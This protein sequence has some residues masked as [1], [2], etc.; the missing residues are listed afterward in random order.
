[1]ALIALVTY[2]TNENQKAKFLQKTLRSL[3]ETVDG[4]KHRVYIVNNASTGHLAKNIVDGYMLDFN[5]MHLSEN[6]G[7]ARGINQAW[8]HRRPGEHCIKMDDDVV[9][10]NAGW[11]DEME[12][13]IK[14]D[15]NIGIVGLKRKDCWE[16]PDETEPHKKSELKMINPRGEKWCIVEKMQHI[17]GTCQMYNSALLDKIGYLYQPGLYGY[18]DVLASHRSQIAGFY[19]CMIPHIEIDHI[20]PGDTPYQKWKESVSGEGGTGPEVRQI[21]R[22]YYSGAKSIYHELY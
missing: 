7:T 21:I 6:I 18:D 9:I 10:H 8:R 12:Y 3:R 20:D 22:D 13:A 15:P 5:V 14:C 2:C 19:N 11:A 4:R 1:M 16:R 17:I